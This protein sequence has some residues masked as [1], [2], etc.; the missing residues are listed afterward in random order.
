[1][2]YMDILEQKAIENKKIKLLMKLKKQKEAE[3]QEVVMEL[4]KLIQK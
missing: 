3:L 4:R 2:S 1:M